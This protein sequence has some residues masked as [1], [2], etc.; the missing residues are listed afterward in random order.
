MDDQKKI[1]SIFSE[2]FNSESHIL[3]ELKENHFCIEVKN[4]IIHK[5]VE[6]SNSIS[7]EYIDTITLCGAENWYKI[8]DSIEVNCKKCNELLKINIK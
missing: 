3:Y 4:N 6:V 8:H 2:L 5:Q 1:Q 7:N